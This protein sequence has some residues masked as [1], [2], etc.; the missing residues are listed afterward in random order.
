MNVYF[1]TCAFF[2][3]CM[4]TICEETKEV[5]RHKWSHSHVFKNK[6][7]ILIII[8]KYEVANSLFTEKV[9]ILKIQGSKKISAVPSL[10]TRSLV[11]LFFEI[12]KE[13]YRQTKNKGLR[14]PHLQFRFHSASAKPTCSKVMQN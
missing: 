12:N 11:N 2:V 1:M 4:R 8:Y 14:H 7:Y 9:M 6:S 3:C 10:T 5:L 13:T